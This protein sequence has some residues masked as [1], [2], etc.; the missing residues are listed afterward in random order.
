M[1]SNLCLN[2]NLSK[3][4]KIRYNQNVERE[5]LLGRLMGSQGMGLVVHKLLTAQRE[6]HP[7]VHS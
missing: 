6:L 2:V 7:L 1:G 4:Y 3:C 5:L